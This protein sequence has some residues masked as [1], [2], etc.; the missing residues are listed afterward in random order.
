[1]IQFK[2]KKPRF[3]NI[4]S[5]E[6]T[7]ACLH[8]F[9][10]TRFRFLTLKGNSEVTMKKFA[11]YILLLILTFSLN[12]IEIEP[13][14]VSGNWTIDDSPYQILGDIQV[15]NGDSLIIDP[16]CVIEFQGHYAMDIF[17]HIIA[18]GTPISKITFTVADTTGFSDVGSTA[19]GWHGLRITNTGSW[20]EQTELEYCTFMFGKA[21]GYTEADNYGGAIHISE[22][23]LAKISYCTFKHNLAGNGGAIACYNSFIL[24]MLNGCTFA[25]NRAVR[26]NS[27]YGLGG[28]VFTNSSYTGAINNCL[29]YENTAWQ[30]GACYLESDYPQF[31]NCTI[32]DNQSDSNAAG[33]YS[34]TYFTATNSIIWNNMVNEDIDNYIGNGNFVNCNINEIMEYDY[35]MNCISVDPLFSES[36]EH[37]YSLNQDSYCID[38]GILFDEN[39]DIDFDIM[40]NPRVYE[41]GNAITDIGAYEFQGSAN[42]AMKPNFSL[43]GGSY[44]SRIEV[45]LSSA[46]EDAQI[47]YSLDGSDPTQAS[48]LY[49]TPIIL[50]DDVTVK[51]IA[52][53]AGINPSFVIEEVYEIGHLRGYLSGTIYNRSEPYPVEANIYINGG[54]SLTIE[55]GVVLEFMGSY[56]FSVDGSLLAEGS[57]TDPIHFTRADTTG[58]SGNN[59]DIGGW[60]GIRILSYE[61]NPVLIKHCIIEYAKNYEGSYQSNTGGGI[62][63][64]GYGKP[65]IENCHIENCKALKG[66][67]IG[68]RYGEAELIGNFFKNNIAYNKGGAVY[69]GASEDFGNE[70]YAYNNLFEDNLATVGNSIYINTPI[71]YF[72]NNTVIDNGYSNNEMIAVYQENSSKFINNIVWRTE[73]T[74]PVITLSINN[75]VDF[76]NCNILG[77]FENINFSNSIYTGDYLN[78]ISLDP[79]FSEEDGFAYNLQESSYCV[80]SGTL[81]GLEDI[82]SE[83]DFLGNPRVY[84]GSI[85]RVDIGACEF[86]HESLVTMKPEISL[87]SGYYPETQTLEIICLT[88]NSNIYYTTDGSEPDESSNL[89]NNPLTIANNAT[90]KAIAYTA[91]FS[92]SLIKEASYTFGTPLSGSLTGTLSLENSPYILTDSAIIE[93]GN[94]LT[95]EP[96]VEVWAAGNFGIMVEGSLSAI[97]TET[98]S[99][100]FSCINVV[101]SWQGFEL[102]NISHDQE[103]SFD[104]CVFTKCMKVEDQGARGGAIY[105]NNYH[106]LTITNCRFERNNSVSGGAIA[107]YSSHITV[108]NCLFVNNSSSSGGGA[109]F[110]VGGLP[111]VQNNVFMHNNGGSRGG[112]M[113]YDYAYG[114]IHNNV[115]GFNSAYTGGAVSCYNAHPHM[116]GNLFYKNSARNNGCALSLSNFFNDE[117]ANCTFVDNYSTIGNNSASAIYCLET[118]SPHFYNSIFLNP[119]IREVYAIVSFQP[120]YPEFYNC[121]GDIGNYIGENNIEE[122]PL[123]VSAENYNYHLQDDSPC[124]DTGLN[125]PYGVEWLDWDLDYNERIWDGDNDGVATIDMGVYEFGAPISDLDDPIIPIPEKFLLSNYPNPFNPTTTIKFSIPEDGKVQLTIY[126]I[127]G[128]KVKSLVNDDFKAGNHEENWNGIDESGNYVSSGVYF[129]K[130]SLNGKSKKIKKCLLLK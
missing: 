25:N 35:S 9:N 56:S 110:G 75:D 77:G 80:N 52:I 27:E 64:R 50:E 125:D 30:G 119:D 44:S 90:I 48:N 67:G 107:M 78:N 28:A 32:A 46:T 96:G 8:V 6:A 22:F 16:G 120:C 91:G 108:K 57:S 117:I 97:G 109:I 68:I 38:E 54:S 18:R 66:G 123:F 99:I 72:I 41:Q 39:V 51:A 14:N 122:D 86:Q 127:K 112:A 29:F 101:N 60:K 17:G 106:D 76:I 23:G 63:I 82:L 100:S 70:I 7:C 92:A 88:E 95:I 59:N 33:I 1:M 43:A 87:E 73:G 104:Y 130:L 5:T 3:L 4:F 37:P 34:S 47:Y 12:A 2:L 53:S 61:E 94:S 65:R 118:S 128:Q 83:Y 55:P 93:I 103:S 84:D 98:D 89:Y 126:N 114:A 62:G 36:N 20:P 15:I 24:P 121:L 129:Y 105:V 111:I 116:Q 26:T 40:G 58:F 11:A 45:E 74:E 115:F 13:G 10:R 124:I 49:S 79:E 19:G 113:Y 81:S 102:S 71:V 21:T 85:D 42:H 69:F 31:K